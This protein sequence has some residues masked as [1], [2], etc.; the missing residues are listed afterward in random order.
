MNLINSP[1]SEKKWIKTETKKTH[2]VWHGSFSRTSFTNG[3]AKDHINYW[4][5]LAEKHGAPYL[6]DREGK[7]YK[8][9]DEKYWIYHLNIPTSRG[10]Y[11]K[12]SIPITLL[13]ELQLLKKNGQYYA[14][15]NER[16]ANLYTGPVFTNNWR[17]YTEWARLSG[18]QVDSAIELTK[19]VCGRHGMDPTF[20]V[21]RDWDPK[22]WER[23]T[24]LTHAQAKR[25]VRDLII[26]PWVIDKIKAAGIKVVDS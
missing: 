4:E 24:I 5:N 22:I 15:D 16:A 12:Q 21:T 14:F 19:E 10:V 25:E 18:P 20:A 17:G 23:A 1:L 6:I 11:D 2:V 13:N 7:I 26:E 8:T 3:T 9:F